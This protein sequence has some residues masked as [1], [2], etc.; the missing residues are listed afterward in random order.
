MVVEKERYLLPREKGIEKHQL[1][2]GK[3]VLGW[4]WAIM[5]A[6]GTLGYHSSGG[7]RGLPC[8]RYGILYSRTVRCGFC[9]SPATPACCDVVGSSNIGSEPVVEGCWPSNCSFRN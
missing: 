9:C 3:V 6:V 7:V 8:R 5:G 4:I 2:E 1:S